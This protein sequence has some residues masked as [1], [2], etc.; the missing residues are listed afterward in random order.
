[1]PVNPTPASN[2]ASSSQP[3]DS[4]RRPHRPAIIAGVI[5]TYIS[6]GSTFEI[7]GTTFAAIG[8]RRLRSLAHAPHAQRAA[9]TER[10]FPLTERAEQRLVQASSAN[11]R[12]QAS[13]SPTRAHRR[14]RSSLRRVC[15]L[16]AHQE[17]SVFS[18]A[19]YGDLSEHHKRLPGVITTIFTTALLI[20]ASA[21]TRHAG[22]RLL[23]QRPRCPC[24]WSGSRPARRAAAGQRPT[25]AR[26]GRRLCRLATT[27]P[28]RSR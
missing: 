21:F 17:G 8:R 7:C 24:R 3:L 13:T 23:R 18:R 19:A 20:A 15:F 22:V 2:A 4:G 10:R 26:G 27:P 14:Q 11:L 5:T 1:M 9:Q 28:P 25:R 6:L 16:V 12:P